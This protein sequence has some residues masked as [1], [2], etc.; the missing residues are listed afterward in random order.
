MSVTPTEILEAAKGF[1]KGNSEV[2]W[3]NAVSRAYYAAYHRSTRSPEAIPHLIALGIEQP[4]WGAAIL[5]SLDRYDD[6]KLMPYREELKEM[7]SRM[8][9]LSLEEGDPE[10]VARLQDFLSMFADPP[11]GAPR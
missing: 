10:T 3:R 1:A 7:L 8:R 6:A 9:L 11:S 5:E 4:F 2:D